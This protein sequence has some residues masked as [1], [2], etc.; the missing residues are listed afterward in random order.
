MWIRAGTAGDDEDDGGETTMT[1]LP[2]QDDEE[3]KY[4]T[5][6]FSTFVRSLSIDDDGGAT[7]D[8]KL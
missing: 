2:I 7:E 5:R 8:S 1:R 3:F 4:S 6:T